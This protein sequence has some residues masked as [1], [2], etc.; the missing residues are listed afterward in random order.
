V[1]GSSIRGH[2]HALRFYWPKPLTK[3]WKS[4]P[5]HELHLVVAEQGRPLGN[6]CRYD[7]DLV[8]LTPQDPHRL[9]AA[10][11]IAPVVEC[12]PA[13]TPA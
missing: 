2:E 11:V 7:R 10:V 1:L 5:R 6:E 4:W 8:A 13:A 9:R 3:A 12:A